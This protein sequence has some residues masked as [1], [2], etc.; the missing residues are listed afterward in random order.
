LGKRFGN[1][2]YAAENALR[3]GFPVERRQ[4][5]TPQGAAGT[6]CSGLAQSPWAE[7][8][9]PG[10][11]NFNMPCRLLFSAALVSRSS[12]ALCGADQEPLISQRARSR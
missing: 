2:A 1:D 12:G 11:F 9:N 7:M 8:H 5:P 6:V 3:D 4:L 10:V